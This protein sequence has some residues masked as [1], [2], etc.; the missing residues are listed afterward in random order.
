MDLIEW[1]FGKEKAEPK[2]KVDQEIKITHK[3][4]LKKER[5]D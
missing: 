5:S 2:K 1:M 4:E 3:E